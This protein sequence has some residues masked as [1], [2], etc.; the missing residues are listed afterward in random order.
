L[1]KS[2]LGIFLYDQ[3]RFFLMKNVLG[4]GLEFSYLGRIARIDGSCGARLRMD[5]MLVIFRRMGKTPEWKERLSER[6]GLLQAR[7][8]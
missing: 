4:P 8:R 1:D 7:W 2:P 5:S 3:L 6:Q